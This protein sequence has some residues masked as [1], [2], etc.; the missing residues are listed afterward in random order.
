M[1]LKIGKASMEIV[2]VSD[3][4]EAEIAGLI[5]QYGAQRYRAAQ[6]FDW[7]GRGAA[8]FGEMTDLPAEL[9]ASLARDA[10]VGTPLICGMRRSAVDGTVKYALRAHDGNAIECALMRYR[11][12]LT[13]CVS[14]Q[15]GCRMGCAFCASRPSGFSRSLSAGEMLGQVAAVRR[16][17]GEDIGHVVVMGVGE[18]FDNYENTMKFVR[19]LNTHARPGVT[20]PRSRSGMADGR[21]G[22]SLAD[23]H[24]GTRIVDGRMG[25]GLADGR[26]KPGVGARKI[27]ISTCGIVPGILRLADEGVQVGLSVSLHAADDALR[28][29]LMP[30]ARKHSIDKLLEGCKIYTY[31]T[32]RRLT[33]EY[34]LFDGVN[35]APADAWLLARRLKGISCHVNLIPANMVEGSGFKPSPRVAVERFAGLL[36]S[37][38]VL[39]TIRRELGSDIGAACGQLRN[40]FADGGA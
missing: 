38:G 24:I 31:N 13:L 19:L 28:R 15:A 35:D 7:I 33:F 6:I 12:G 32:K 2:S 11:H 10:R 1:R 22:S 20:K 26:A 18:P 39:A 9:R 17:F 30:V 40:S 8:S 27:T 34:A 5:S 36:R 21:M 23:G 37:G 14:S 16:S 25:S 29:R 3:L 4:D